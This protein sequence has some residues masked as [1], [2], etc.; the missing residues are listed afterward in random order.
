[1]RKKSDTTP[2][3]L[4][5]KLGIQVHLST[6]WYRLRRLGPTFKKTLTAAEQE[7]EGRRLQRDAWQAAQPMLDPAR[8][9]FVDETGLDTAM[10]RRTGWGDCGQRVRG[11]SSQKHWHTSTFVAVLGQR[12]L[13]APMV[14]RGP[15]DGS[16][17]KP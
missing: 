9:V 10:V 14:S 5:Q 12:G 3:E 16:L 2:V 8:L 4:R 13:T 1:L 11:S 7:C 15:M 17:F 6:L